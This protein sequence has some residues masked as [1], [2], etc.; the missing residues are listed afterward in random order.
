MPNAASFSP[1]ASSSVRNQTTPAALPTCA[2]HDTSIVQAP[3]K[4]PDRQWFHKVA[5][6]TTSPRFIYKA[7]R[8]LIRRGNGPV[9]ERAMIVHPSLDIVNAAVDLEQEA[10]LAQSPV[11]VHRNKVDNVPA[12]FRPGSLGTCTPLEPHVAAALFWDWAHLEQV[13]RSLR[14]CTPSAA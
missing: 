9:L 12:P 5:I 8:R 14:P 11:N 6:G 2:A 13:V 4:S 3:L 10:E 7:L 1:P